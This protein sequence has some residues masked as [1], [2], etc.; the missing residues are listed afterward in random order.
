MAIDFKPKSKIDF[1]P[2]VSATSQP[3]QSTA[4]SIWQSLASG[5]P[6]FPAQPNENPL[7]SIAKGIGNI[8]SGIIPTVTGVVQAFNPIEVGKNVIRTSQELSDT[9]KEFG[10]PETAI[11]LAKELPSAAA[12]VLLPE[13]IRKFF[14][15]DFQGAR[16][17]LE[18]APTQSVVPIILAARGIAEM[19]GQGQ[20]FDTAMLKP[21]SLATDIAA[22]TA[23]TAGGLLKT[24]GEGMTGLVVPM[25]KSTA[26]SMQ[27]YEAY[28]PTIFERVQNLIS[29]K[30]TA[31]LTKPTTE[32]QTVAKLVTPGTEWQLGVNA[33]RASSKLWNE[34]VAPALDESSA[35]TNIPT[36]FDNLQEKIISENPDLSRR[37]TLLNALESLKQDFGNVRGNVGDARLQ[38]YKEGWA[39]FVPEKA[40]RGEPI[41]G[42][43][44]E[45]RNLAAD[46][47]RK[48]IYEHLGPEI[49]Q[50]YIDYGNLQSIQEAGIKSID[51]LRSKSWTKQVWEEVIDKAVTPVATIAGKVLYKTGEG[52]EFIGD[53]GAKKI[54]D[55]IGKTPQAIQNINKN[56][57]IGL[58]IEDVSGKAQGEIPN[59][60]AQAKN[61]KSAEEFVNSFSKQFHGSPKADLQEIGFGTGVRSNPFMGTSKEV[62]SPSIFFSKDKGVAETFAK[63]RVE[64]LQTKDIKGTPTVYERFINKKGLLD[65]TKPQN[66][67]K[68]FEK[69]KI[70]VESE[71]EGLVPN[72]GLGEDFSDALAGGR[73]EMGDLFKIFDDPKLVKKFKDAGYS[74]VRLIEKN[75]LGE[76]TAIF[77]P[78]KAFTKSQ[79]TKI[80]EEANKK[81]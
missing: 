78:K 81:K 70:S 48:I 10:L 52:L 55:I 12:Q 49:K 19:K 67:D 26:L 17:A 9:I 44:N 37:N 53:A 32:A 54:K 31:E 36:F 72:Y 63:N 43:L 56:P 59:L 77:D 46:Q 13:F 18:N 27:A 4:D 79:L 45:V 11:G 8:P 40:Y 60:S 64:Y 24:A 38:M 20:Q 6:T 69:L 16:M 33:K 3:Q 30:P 15:G 2:I 75:N 58:S 21:A 34:T 47:A 14:T 5:K 57:Q 73:V 35:K 76:S 65:L 66:I 68:V 61:F 74:G 1:K 22:K 39:K 62:Q 29:N 71:L 25:E 23:G 50:A 42:A 7:T 80:W 51:A 41:A 28:K